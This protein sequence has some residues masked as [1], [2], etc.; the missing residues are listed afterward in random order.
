MNQ[1][2]Y[3]PEDSLLNA[4]NKINAFWLAAVI[5]GGIVLAD[6]V[7]SSFVFVIVMIAGLAWASS[8]RHI[9]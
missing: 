4:R 8:K 1:A 6:A 3:L 2:T 5:L 9:R 7:G